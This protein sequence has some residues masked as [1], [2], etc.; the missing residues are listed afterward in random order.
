MCSLI[1]KWCT[2]T[3]STHNVGNVA[4]EQV[5]L[6]S[7]CEINVAGVRNVEVR[8]AIST[9]PNPNPIRNCKLSLLEMAKSNITRSSATLPTMSARIKSDDKLY[10]NQDTK[11]E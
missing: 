2:T 8:P 4:D 6:F 7:H 5:I 3:H 11:Y 1:R 10:K 9:D